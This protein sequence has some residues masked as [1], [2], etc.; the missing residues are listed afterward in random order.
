MSYRFIF[1]GFVNVHI[2]VSG[3][4][5]GV[6]RRWFLLGIWFLFSLY[7]IGLW[8]MSVFSNIT[9]FST[10][11]LWN[12]LFFNFLCCQIIYEILIF[13]CRSRVKLEKRLWGRYGEL[14]LPYN[15][16]CFSK[17]AFTLLLRNVEIRAS[18]SV[19]AS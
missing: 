9:N 19:S 1:I 16:T 11:F 4:L 15:F 12:S 2:N 17:S 5:W 7:V 14:I 18:A 6:V 13:V 10:D 8:H 3:V